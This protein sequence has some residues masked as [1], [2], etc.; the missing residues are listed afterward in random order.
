VTGVSADTLFELV[1]AG[2]DLSNSGIPRVIVPAGGRVE[3]SIDVA[4]AQRA[5]LKAGGYDLP[6]IARGSK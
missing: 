5:I 2:A 4:A 6:E 1:R 3:Q